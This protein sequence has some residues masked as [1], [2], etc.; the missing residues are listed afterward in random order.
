MSIPGFTADASFGKD[1]EGLR[2]PFVC[3]R[4]RNGSAPRSAL[5][6]R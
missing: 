1:Q 4:S 5:P 2:H 6:F 3:I